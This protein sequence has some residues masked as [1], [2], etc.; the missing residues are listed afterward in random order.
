MR[1]VDGRLAPIEQHARQSM[2]LANAH[3]QIEVAHAWPGFSDH[4][5]QITAA[6]AAANAAGRVLPLADAYVQVVAPSLATTRETLKTELR[7][8]I[9]AEL[10]AT[11][12]RTTDTIN[13]GRRP[14]ASARPA[15]ERELVDLIE[16]EVQRRK[17]V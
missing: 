14:L 6:I 4:V 8:E 17:L 11:T 13:P 16:E 15:R 9:L 12:E 1:E 2:A 5:E 10:A 7:K 3:A